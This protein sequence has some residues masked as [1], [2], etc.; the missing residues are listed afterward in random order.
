MHEGWAGVFFLEIPTHRYQ[1]HD[2]C[3][4]NDDDHEPF[5]RVA[6]LK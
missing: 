6:L 4:A 2:R 3:D 5:R 1:N